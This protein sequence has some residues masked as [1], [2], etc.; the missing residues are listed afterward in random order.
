MIWDISVP[1]PDPQV[2]TS[3]VG[4][5]TFLTVQGFLW[6][7]CFEV[8]GLSAQ[9]LYGGANGFLLSIWVNSHMALR[10]TNL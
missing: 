4:P 6:Y 5:R 1:L 2:G 8:C 3:V 10:N 9:Q 7:N